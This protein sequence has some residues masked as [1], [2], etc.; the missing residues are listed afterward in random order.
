[1]LLHFPNCRYRPREHDSDNS[2]GHKNFASNWIVAVSFWPDLDSLGRTNRPMCR[3][4]ALQSFTQ[5]ADYTIATK[6]IK[7]FS[8]IDLCT[9][10]GN[11]IPRFC[12]F[13]G[14]LHQENSKPVFNRIQSHN[15]LEVMFQMLIRSY[16]PKLS[17]YLTPGVPSHSTCTLAKYS[18]Y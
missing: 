12:V 9:V 4:I 10:S 3:A 1:M 13:C 8:F 6:R 15:I 16:C 7:L 14:S 17:R 11:F 5:Y 2:P 18:L